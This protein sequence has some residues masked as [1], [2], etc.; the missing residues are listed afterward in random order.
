MG[1]AFLHVIYVKPDVLYYVL[2]TEVTSKKLNKFK[3]LTDYYGECSSDKWRRKSVKVEIG[4]IKGF[5]AGSERHV[6]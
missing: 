2:M 5:I 6:G 3:V 1:Y 4:Q